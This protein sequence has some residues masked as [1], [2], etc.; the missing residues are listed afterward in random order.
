MKKF[1]TSFNGYNKEEVNQL[2]AMYAKEY[3]NLLNKLKVQD[4][5]L[6]KYKNLENTLN[7]TI[8]AAEDTSNQIKRLAKEEGRNIIEEAKRNA[9]KILNEALLKTEKIERDGEELERR[10]HEF[11]RKFK[12]AVENE[13]EI[14]DEIADK[15]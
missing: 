2:V 9:S 7:K 6:E 11:K 10:V 5:E 14:I 1:S 15:Y 3:E 13:V 8:L 4:A 12:Q